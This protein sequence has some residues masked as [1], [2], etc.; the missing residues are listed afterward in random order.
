[1][2]QEKISTGTAAT[3]SAVMQVFSVYC[4]KSLGL[5]LAEVSPG[6]PLTDPELTPQARGAKPI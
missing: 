6:L 5:Q 4:D 1:M 3:V 2:P